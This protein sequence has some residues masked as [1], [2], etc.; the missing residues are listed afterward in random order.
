MCLNIK[1]GKQKQ[2]IKKKTHKKIHDF[3]WK[4]AEKVAGVGWQLATVAGD[5]RWLEVG[6]RPKRLGLKLVLRAL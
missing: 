4:S 5:W 2:R 1:V 6:A 3:F